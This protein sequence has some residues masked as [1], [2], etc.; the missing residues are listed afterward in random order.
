MPYS[1]S[2]LFLTLDVYSKDTWFVRTEEEK[3]ARIKLTDSCVEV[4]LYKYK[5]ERQFK[6][7]TESL[8]FVERSFVRYYYENYFRQE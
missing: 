2:R 4:W 3:Y 5:Y 6:T 7:L 1:K 8:K